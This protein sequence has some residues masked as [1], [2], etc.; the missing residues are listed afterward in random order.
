[1]YIIYT[2]I[3]DHVNVFENYLHCPHV[4]DLHLH[5]IYTLYISLLTFTHTIF[6]Q[7]MNYLLL[8]LKFLI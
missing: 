1:M 4:N 7:T 8:D 3:W 6:V 5:G 2:F